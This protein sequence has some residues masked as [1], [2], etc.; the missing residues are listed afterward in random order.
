MSEI[1]ITL[2]SHRK[3][4]PKDSYSATLLRAKEQSLQNAIKAHSKRHSRLSAHQNHPSTHSHPISKPLPQHPP[5]PTDLTET[6]SLTQSP[7]E[8]PR[9]SAPKH[10]S[11]S[12]HASFAPARF[13]RQPQFKILLPS[14]PSKALLEQFQNPQLLGGMP[15]QSAEMIMQILQKAVRSKVSEEIFG[16]RWV[17]IWN[18]WVWR[19][20]GFLGDVR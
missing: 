19:G 15:P 10:P 6:L 1:G 14:S 18:W 13:H 20:P 11:Y 2:N 3:L 17:W 5:P 7:Q 9:E 16:K 12:T 8:T 4:P